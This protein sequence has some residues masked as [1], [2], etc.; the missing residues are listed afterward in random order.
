MTRVKEILK[1][2]KRIVDF[3]QYLRLYHFL[4]KLI[5]IIYSPLRYKTPTPNVFLGQLIWTITL[6]IF[7]KIF[8]EIL[9]NVK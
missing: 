6:Q 8:G 3:F 7:L 2:I 5:Q 4:S 9:I 1:K